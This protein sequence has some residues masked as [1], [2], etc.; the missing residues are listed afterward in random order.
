MEE[1]MHVGAHDFGLHAALNNRGKRR[2]EIKRPPLHG[3]MAQL[4]RGGFGLQ[5]RQSMTFARGDGNCTCRRKKPRRCDAVHRR[6]SAVNVGRRRD[7]PALARYEGIIAMNIVNR[8]F[9]LANAA[10]IKI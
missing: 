1:L 8:V 2:I 7:Q 6:D 4:A 5:A 9:V 3:G 10:S